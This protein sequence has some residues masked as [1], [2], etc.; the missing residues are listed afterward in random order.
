MTEI[1][2][3]R[4]RSTSK[5][6]SF[7][8]T[9]KERIS[10][11]VL[12]VYL[13]NDRLAG[14]AR[15]CP[16]DHTDRIECNA[17]GWRRIGWYRVEDG[18]NNWQQLINLT[19]AS[20]GECYNPAKNIVVKTV[21]EEIGVT[22]RHGTKNFLMRGT[23]FFIIFHTVLVFLFWKSSKMARLRKFSNLSPTGRN[24]E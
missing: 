2:W 23:F 22:T 1:K 15:N 8:K 11:L 18:Q 6:C 16:L 7:W 21:V 3:R 20:K 13:E 24:S 5:P 4:K 12:V 17:E 14:H 19:A 9:N 10:S